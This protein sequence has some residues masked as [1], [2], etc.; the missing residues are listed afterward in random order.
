ARPA[1]LP[2][3]SAGPPLP[4]PFTFTGVAGIVRG[5]DAPSPQ[6]VQGTT[7]LFASWSDGGAQAHAISTPAVNTTYKAVF[8]KARASLV[9]P[10]PRGVLDGSVATFAWNAGRGV[11]AYRLDVG[12]TAGGTQI[13]SSNTLSV[14]SVTVTGLPT[15]GGTIYARL[16]S[17]FG[18]V[19]EYEDVTY[20]AAPAGR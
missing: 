9:T 20:T 19:W 4:P 2:A 18:G 6:F 13:F 10:L 1:A 14:R 8:V 12:T 7:W 15:G 17:L 16:W 11:T 5:L 3:L